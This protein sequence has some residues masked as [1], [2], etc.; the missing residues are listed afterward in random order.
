MNNPITDLPLFNTATTSTT[1]R[2][3]SQRA[4]VFV[5]PVSPPQ[6]Q[7]SSAPPAGPALEQAIGRLNEH[8]EQKHTDLKFRIDDVLNSVVVSVVDAQD[9]TVLQQIPSEVALRIARYLAETNS[10]LIKAEA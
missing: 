9:G 4:S 8:F 1:A 2:G 5:A 3:E 7:E 10:G 6:S